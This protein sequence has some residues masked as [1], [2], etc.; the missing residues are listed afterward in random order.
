MPK[1]AADLVLVPTRRKAGINAL[2]VISSVGPRKI[3]GSAEE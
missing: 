3:K 1:S 2:V